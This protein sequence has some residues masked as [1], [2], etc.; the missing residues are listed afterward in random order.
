M[1]MIK[2]VGMIMVIVSA[3]LLVLYT[4]I[5]FFPPVPG[6]DIFLIKVSVYLQA[7]I[8]LLVFAMV[9]FIL[10]KLTRS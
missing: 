9:G 1:N 7:I 8:S 3:L 6:W 4:W 10:Y 2:K 5:L